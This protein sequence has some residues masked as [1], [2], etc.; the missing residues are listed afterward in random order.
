MK[1]LTFVLLIGG[2]FLLTATPRIEATAVR[3]T[4]NFVDT[5]GLPFAPDY[6]PT[7]Y[8]ELDDDDPN[9][10][11]PDDYL[12]ALS[13]SFMVPAG[14]LWNTDDYGSVWAHNDASGFPSTISFGLWDTVAPTARGFQLEA[15]FEPT[16]PLPGSPLFEWGITVWPTTATWHHPAYGT[17]TVSL[18]AIPEPASMLL[19]GSGLIGLAAFRRKFRKR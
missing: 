16:S 7:G 15:F 14:H 3:Y 17:Y 5:S 8:F 1:K 19:L 9:F 4:V 6:L 2:I 18:A 10:G 13:W 11:V 12:W